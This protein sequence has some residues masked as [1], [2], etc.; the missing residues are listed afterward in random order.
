[1]I[2]FQVKDHFIIMTTE[3]S[4]FVKIGDKHERWN[5]IM[6]PNDECVA[7]S[8]KRDLSNRDPDIYFKSTDNNPLNCDSE[9]MYFFRDENSY[10]TTR[11]RVWRFECGEIDRNATPGIFDTWTRINTWNVNVE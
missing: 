5:F 4:L 1:M 9:G 6:T 10:Y 11:I 8:I 3:D 2:F 7:L